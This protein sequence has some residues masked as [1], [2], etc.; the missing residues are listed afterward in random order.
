M[1][2]KFTHLSLY[3]LA[4][5]V[6]PAGL[7]LLFAPQLALQLML[8]NTTYDAEALRLA[9][10]ALTSLGI[11]V[12]QMI[13]L[14]L[15]ALYPTT[16]VVRVFILSGLSYLYVTTANPFF[17]VLIGIVGLGLVLTSVAYAID[18][19]RPL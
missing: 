12:V 5:Y 8:S 9:G 15:E 13:R 10:I 14:R 4:S 6:V 3:Y 19:R 1:R 16:L 18:R 7:T 2:L 11:F 17:L